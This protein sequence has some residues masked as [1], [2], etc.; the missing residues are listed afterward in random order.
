[1]D[2][3]IIDDSRIR[4]I[5]MISSI[6]EIT[7]LWDLTL[8]RVEEKLGERQSFD[9]FFAG[10]YI[11]E[12]R[13][14]KIQVVVD[15]D[16][17]RALLDTKYR[18][19]LT[20]IVNDITEDVYVLEFVS[21]AEIKKNN[22]IEQPTSSFQGSTP[23]FFADA[24]LDPKLTFDSYVVGQFNAEAAHAASFVAKNPGKM[25]NP[26]FLYSHSGLGKTHLMNAIGNY[27]ASQNPRAKILLVS[28]Q[29]FIEEYI[30]YVN[31]EKSSE[32]LTDYINGFDVFLF[33]DVQMLANREKTQD[34]FFIIYNKLIARG[35][36]IVITSDR[37]P[38]ELEKM[39]D[40]L[41][42]RF[43][44]GLIIKIDEPDQETCVAILKKMIVE[45]GFKVEDFDPGIL[46]LYADKFSSNIRQ[47]DG[48][49]SRLIFKCSFKGTS[50]VTMDL[51]IEAAEDLL[52]NRQVSTQVSGQKIINVVADYYNLSPT[53]L[54]SKVRTGQIALAR[55]IAMY[56][57]RY[58]LDVSYK[59]IGDMFGGK[60]H[61]TVMSAITKVEKEL[62]TDESLRDVVEEL[63]K[64]LKS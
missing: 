14:D 52:D 39:Q 19:M 22:R 38:N 13:G 3:S 25:Y 51:A 26:L 53:Q 42:T 55:H 9:S 24:V 30:K 15:K 61:T 63:Q 29:N 8:K 40:R 54:T 35:K 4:V 50:H 23:T 1:M 5:N 49:L 46:Y 7:R 64:R 6:S 12:I 56:L 18:K 31:G 21:S 59:A 45:K 33:D 28:G 47:L 34:F 43:S 60:D 20:D 41:I 27:I 37:Q 58:M 32:S 44:Q 48:A 62:K 10:T 17:A 57:M 11:N 16:L 36:Q 2:Y